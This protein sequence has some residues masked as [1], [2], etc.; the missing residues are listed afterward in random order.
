MPLAC[1]V[2]LAAST[3]HHRL[4]RFNSRISDKLGGRFSDFAP[5]ITYPS[6]ILRTE[7]H[8]A[9]QVMHCTLLEK[10]D[11]GDR[12]F[13]FYS[14]RVQHLFVRKLRRSRLNGRYLRH[15]NTICI[16]V[17]PAQLA[18]FSINKFRVVRPIL[19]YTLVGFVRSDIP[20]EGRERNG[21]LRDLTF[22]FVIRRFR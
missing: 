10:S 1:R 5:G 12:L 13:I 6:R 16:P 14:R 7:Y 15:R 11:T 17:K 21:T 18:R 8:I 20:D 19:I 2:D 4:L 9:R 22:S 3:D